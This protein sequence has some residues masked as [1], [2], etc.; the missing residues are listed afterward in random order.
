MHADEILGHNLDMFLFFY[1]YFSEDMYCVVYVRQNHLLSCEL[2]E[3][4]VN[5]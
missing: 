1:Q 3:L 4:R 5:E 2:K